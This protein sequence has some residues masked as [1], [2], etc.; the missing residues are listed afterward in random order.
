MAINAVLPTQQGALAN[1]FTIVVLRA[2]GRDNLL[3]SR[4]KTGDDK[5]DV[6]GTVHVALLLLPPLVFTDLLMVAEKQLRGSGRQAMCTAATAFV[7]S[8]CTVVNTALA[9]SPATQRRFVQA[10][11]DADLMLLQELKQRQQQPRRELV[12]AIVCR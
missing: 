12:A 1:S 3:P 10:K 2:M 5:R 11:S 4:L 9:C 6:S 7:A 8:P